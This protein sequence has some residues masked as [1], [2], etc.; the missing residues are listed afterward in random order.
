MALLPVDTV[1]VYAVD[2]FLNTATGHTEDVTVLS[3]AFD[4]NTLSRLNFQLVDP[5]DALQNFRY[6]MKFLKTSGLKPV[7]RITDF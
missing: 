7:E 5:S 6:N 2:S 4:R 1:V 3:V